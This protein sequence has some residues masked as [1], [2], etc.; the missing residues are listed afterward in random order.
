MYLQVSWCNLHLEVLYKR[1]SLCF[2]KRFVV[3]R[4]SLSCFKQG[5]PSHCYKELYSTISSILFNTP[6]TI[7]QKAYKVCHNFPKTICF[8]SSF[9]P[10]SC[11]HT[12]MYIHCLL[13]LLSVLLFSQCIDLQNIELS[14]SN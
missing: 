1:H 12:L 4:E 10:F 6:L 14:L 5:I 8:S 13:T 7:N 2:E 11:V 9:L 3:L